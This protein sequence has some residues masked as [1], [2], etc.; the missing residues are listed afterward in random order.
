MKNKKNYEY[1]SGV[2]EIKNVIDGAFDQFKLKNP[3]LT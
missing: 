1:E 2:I 3:T